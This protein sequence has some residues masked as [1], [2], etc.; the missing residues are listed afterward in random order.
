M[1]R[2]IAY[3]ARIN[4]I[5]TLITNQEELKRAVKATQDEYNK[6]DFGSKKRDEALK[7]LGALKQ[8]QKEN[9]AEIR[10]S[11]RAFERSA[12]AGRE[13]YRSLNAELV[14]LRNQ[15]KNLSRAEREGQIGADLVERIQVLDTELKSIDS[16]IGNNQRNVGNYASALAGLGGI[17][18]NVFT[19]IPGAITAVGTAA[20]AASKELFEMAGRVRDVQTQINALTGATGE[21][22]DEYTIRITA[23]NKT[24]GTTTEE[25]L[26]ASNAASQQLGI[27]FSDALTRIEEGFIAGSN[28]NGDFLDQVREYP[29]FIDEAGLSADNFFAIINQSVKEGIYSDKGIDAVK[30]ATIRLRELP[31]ATIAGLEALSLTAEEVSAVI[32]EEGIGAAI[33]LVGERLGSLEEDAPE[34]GQ[35][36]AGIFGGPG[37]DAG[38]RFLA[39]LENINAETG[40]LIDTTSEYQQEQLR[41][42][43][44]NQRFA[45]VQNEIA[46]Q[47]GGTGATLGNLVT[48]IQ[49]AVLQAVSALIARGRALFEIFEPVRDSFIRLFQALGFV[50]EQG[51]KTEAAIG[52]INAAFA[53]GDIIYKGVAAALTFVIDQLTKV[54]NFGRRIAEFL[55]VNK[56]FEAGLEALGGTSQDAGEKISNAGDKTEKAAEQTKKAADALEDFTKKTNEAGIAAE[57]F[58]EGSIAALRQKVNDLKKELEQGAPENVEGLLSQLLDAEAAL[59]KAENFKRLLRER[60]SEGADFQPLGILQQTEGAVNRNAGPLQNVRDFNDEVVN[61]VK[62][63]NERITQEEAAQAERLQALQEN[64]FGG[65]SEAANIIGQVQTNRINKE[66]EAL[67]ER[68]Q[69]ELELAGE[70]VELRTE[71]EEKFAKEKERLEREALEVQ[72]QARVATALVSLAEGIVNIIAAPSTIPDPFGAIYKAGRIAFLTATTAAQ[73]GEINS[74]SIGARG[75]LATVGDAFNRVIMEDGGRIVAGVARGRTHGDTGGG[76]ALSLNGLPVLIENGEAVQSDEYGN[77][78]VINKR[79]S[80]VFSRELRAMEKLSFAGKSKVLSAINNYKGYGIPFAQEGLLVPNV[81]PLGGG[82]SS[83]ISNATGATALRAED[84]GA[85]AAALQNAAYSGTREG[86]GDG[87]LTANRQKERE[88]IR[89]RRT[90]V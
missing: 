25:V 12:D 52:L 21:D 84:I 61:I 9:R 67:E 71:A 47:I 79:S 8:I 66:V 28:A 32:S 26:R 39:S 70:N 85:L 29:T 62:N 13:S 77:K 35:A 60:L 75:L 49:T 22:L 87:V 43:E 38:V 31:T 58:A 73:I 69:K 24:F 17:D 72:K 80:A 54:V 40:S 56:L 23:L 53:A 83:T 74:A 37:E 86:V 27:S 59:N 78:A 4:G 42:L 48:Q 46:N 55:G 30:E 51:R 33:G 45:S 76:I 89:A 10:S 19:S 5:D 14:E 20:V 82:A 41:T 64:I 63:R 36:I 68:Y 57:N 88:A 1:A 44:V 90:G 50:D 7:Q 11:Q 15:F 18:L 65:I 3:E 6:S 34:V 81:L 2:V 16:T